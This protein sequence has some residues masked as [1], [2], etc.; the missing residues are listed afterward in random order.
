MARIDAELG[1]RGD[2][3]RDVLPGRAVAEHHAHA[4]AHA[5]DRILE[6]RSL[7]VVVGAAGCIPVKG[8]AEV[9]RRIVTADHLFGLP[10]SGKLRV[11]LVVSADHGGKV[12]H[13]AEPDNA[14]PGERLFYIGGAYDCTRR[15]ETGCGWNAARYLNEDMNGLFARFVDHQT[16]AAKSQHV[17]NLVR[18][19]EHPGGTMRDD[20][21]DKLRDG[22]H[23]RFDV[24]VAVEK[25][26][27]QIASRSVQHL[28]ILTY[29]VRRIAADKGNPLSGNG[30]VGM[31]HHLS[32]LN[33]HPPAVADNQIGAIPPHRHVD[34]LPR[35]FKPERFHAHALQHGLLE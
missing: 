5:G 1:E 29:S 6:T 3:R 4:L 11:Q 33:A 16:H 23:P 18:V 34:Q 32:G 14:R 21:P 30:D 25:P 7:V 8:K 19:D 35:V 26:R 27:D 24:H 13:L 31:L 10:R 2:L 15:L 9:R 22:E 20:R 12:H 28:R 17:G